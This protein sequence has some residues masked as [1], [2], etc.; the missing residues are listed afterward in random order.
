VGVEVQRHIDM[1][2]VHVQ[3]PVLLTHA[4]LP[5]MIERNRGAIINV[6][7]LAAWTHSAGSV[8]YCATKAYLVFFSEALQDELKGTKVRIQALCPGFVRT[9]FHDGESMSKLDLGKIPKWLWV[10][11]DTVV[12][13]SLQNLCGDRVV[14]VPGLFPRLLGRCMRM[15]MLQPLVRALARQR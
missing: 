2:S 1:I 11:T 15:P 12:E 10:T 8:H 5:R 7:S 9:G 14:V 6:S 4:V 13:C 3:T